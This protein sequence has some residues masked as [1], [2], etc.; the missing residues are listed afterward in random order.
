MIKAKTFE[1]CEMVSRAWRTLGML[2]RMNSIA[3]ST[4][5][6]MWDW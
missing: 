4:G 6:S 1:L 2:R 3:D 5:F